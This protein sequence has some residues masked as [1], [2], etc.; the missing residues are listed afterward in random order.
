MY[1]RVIYNLVNLVMYL[2][3]RAHI[4]PRKSTHDF[5]ERDIGLIMPTLQNRSQLTAKITDHVYKYY[6][7]KTTY[8]K[9]RRSS[10]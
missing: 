10:R 1:M 9:H 2:N 7:T 5:P 3:S 8:T 4:Q 6:N